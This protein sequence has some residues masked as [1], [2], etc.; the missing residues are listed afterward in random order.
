MDKVLKYL[1][2]LTGVTCLAIGLYHVVGGPQTIFGGGEVNASTEDRKSTLFRSPVSRSD[3][4]R[5]GFS[6]V[7][8]DEW[9]R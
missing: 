7:G 2:I 5:R 8:S 3:C 6:P 4:W 9:S 1:A